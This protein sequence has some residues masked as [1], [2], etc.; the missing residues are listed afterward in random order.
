MKKKMLTE[1]QAWLFL[2]QLWGRAGKL[3]ASDDDFFVRVDGRRAYGLCNC[4]DCMDQKCV[5]YMDQ[6]IPY[7]VASA[8][9]AKIDSWSPGDGY[10]H[11]HTPAGALRRAAFCRRM[12]KGCE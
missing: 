7:S 5:D 4:V 11:P 6:M 1:K 9:R 10:R 3:P 12:A 2:A 8:M